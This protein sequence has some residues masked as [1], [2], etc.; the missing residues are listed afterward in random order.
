MGKLPES[1][2]DWRVPWTEEDFDADKAA[3][4]VFKL[5]QSLEEQHDKVKERDKEIATLTADLDTAKAAKS[6]TDEEAQAELKDLRK[7]TRELKEAGG[8]PRPEAQQEIDK[9]S[10]GL[11]LGLSLRD[12][13]RLVGKD[14]D[15][16]LEDGKAFAK[17]HGLIDDDDED[18]E[19][20]DTSD[21]TGQETGSKP[22]ARQPSP[23]FRTGSRKDK[24]VE[25]PSNPAE[26]AK[27]LPSLFS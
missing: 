10:V 15:E 4:M 18:P 2:D 3:R 27:S 14:R 9:L 26:A 5:K 16:I 24:L 13:K 25:T 6:G 7:E 21:G 23:T 17:E 19:D 8:K 20:D 22:P 11:E 12:A 1:F